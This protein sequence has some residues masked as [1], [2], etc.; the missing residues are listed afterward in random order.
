MLHYT[1]IAGPKAKAEAEPRNWIAEKRIANPGGGRKTVSFVSLI[2][3]VATWKVIVFLEAQSPRPSL[4]VEFSG[5]KY[6]LICIIDH[7]GYSRNKK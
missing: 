5:G 1:K 6:S 4:G 3:Q 2:T 7:P